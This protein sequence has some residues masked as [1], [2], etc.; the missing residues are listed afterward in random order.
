MQL[1]EIENNF[2]VKFF[3]YNISHI[4]CFSRNQICK[5]SSQI[6]E[7]RTSKK[8]NEIKSHLNFKC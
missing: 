1:E 6:F 7:N 4:F 2:L 5:K 8:E 3:F